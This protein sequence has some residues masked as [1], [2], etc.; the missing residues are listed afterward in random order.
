MLFS[1][2]HLRVKF[3]RKQ[4]PLLTISVI[5][6]SELCCCCHSVLTP[7]GTKC[8]DFLSPPLLKCLK[9]T[10]SLPRRRKCL[11][12]CPLLCLHA[13]LP[14]FVCWFWAQICS[15]DLRLGVALLQ[16]C[17]DLNTHPLS[18]VWWHALLGPPDFSAWSWKSLSSVVGLYLGIDCREEYFSRLPAS[19]L[20][21]S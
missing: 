15:I 12:Y 1:P 14:V 19:Q 17:F 2:E 10:F 7:R 9:P 16:F 6:Q 4:N 13:L 20:V 11:F 3:R 21:C 5:L 18:P 8:Q